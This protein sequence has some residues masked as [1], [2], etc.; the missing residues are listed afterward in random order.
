MAQV[1]IISQILDVIIKEL[2]GLDSGKSL[3]MQI[4]QFNTGT[5]Y[6]C[7]MRR[8]KKIFG[9]SSSDVFIVM[10]VFTI[11]IIFIIGSA[12]HTAVCA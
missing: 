1:Q 2:A 4:V 6:S 9:Y 10:I 3:G 12:D 11:F 5:Y 8:S 7:S